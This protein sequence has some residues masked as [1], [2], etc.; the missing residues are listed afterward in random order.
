LLRYKE[1][2]ILEFPSGHPDS[3]VRV[4]TRFN[5][6]DLNDVFKA[7]ER[8][9]LASLKAKHLVEVLLGFKSDN[10]SLDL[11]NLLMDKDKDKDKNKNKNKKENEILKSLNLKVKSAKNSELLA[12]VR[13]KLD[14]GDL[15]SLL[16]DKDNGVLDF[17]SGETKDGKPEY[18]VE[19][20]SKLGPSD[21]KNLLIDKGNAV[22]ESLLGHPE[23][24]YEALRKLGYLEDLREI[25]EIE[26]DDEKIY[27]HIKKILLN[28]KTSDSIKNKLT[29]ILLKAGFEQA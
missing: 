7:K 16:M 19:V 17:L 15:K 12:C 14:S 29:E 10:L 21:L 24:L 9:L 3:L 23:Q 4:L 5:F 27:E 6:Y 26:V 25:P 18:L 11:A 13:I 2:G 28:F 1:N 8:E 20:L 22:L